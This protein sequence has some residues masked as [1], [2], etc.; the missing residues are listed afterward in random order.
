MKTIALLVLGLS[1]LAGCSQTGST[2]GP[3]TVLSAELPVDGILRFE[4]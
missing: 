4:Q 3:R 2:Q 1:A